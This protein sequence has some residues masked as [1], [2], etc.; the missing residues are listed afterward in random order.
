MLRAQRLPA[1]VLQDGA[2]RLVEKDYAGARADGEEALKASPEDLTAA[3]LITNSYAA[4]GRV[5]KGIERLRQLAEARPGSAPLH[6]LVG[7]W[8]AQQKHTAGGPQVI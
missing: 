8:L 2:L 4:E 5:D 3:L 7:E 1:V 6:L